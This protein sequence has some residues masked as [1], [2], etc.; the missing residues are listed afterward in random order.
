LKI[1]IFDSP[2]ELGE[3]AAADAGEILGRAIEECGRASLV[4]AT[5]Q[6]QVEFLNALVRQSIDWSR[7]AVYQLDE[8]LGLPA[9]HPASL[10]EFIRVHLLSRVQPGEVHLLEE[11]VPILPT[12]DVALVGVGEN[13]HLAFNDPPANF[14]TEAPYITVELD[15]RCREQQVGEGWFANIDD[16]PVTATSMSIRQIMKSREILC[17]VPER[18]KA[19]AVRDCFRGAISPMHPASILQSH[20]KA[21]VFLD[22]ESASLLIAS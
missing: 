3:A 12:I 21:T 14:E 17:A 7:V 22:A 10:A 18:R 15:Q 19:E 8:Y 1:R 4:V 2:R 5:G 16:V 11:G 6:S 9:R 20:P 13:G